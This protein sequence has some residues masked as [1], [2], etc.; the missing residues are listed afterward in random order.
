MKP[1]RLLSETLEEESATDKKLTQIAESTINVEAMS[2]EM[3]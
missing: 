2:G 3:H 1:C